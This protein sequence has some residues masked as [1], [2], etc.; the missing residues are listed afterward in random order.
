MMRVQ[1]QETSTAAR[2]VI[3]LFLWF[4]AGGRERD[5]TRAAGAGGH[6][7]GAES[8]GQERGDQRTLRNGR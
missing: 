7:G 3:M 2:S 4:T 8:L 6:V 1:T 5:S